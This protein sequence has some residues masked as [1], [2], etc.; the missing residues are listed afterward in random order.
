[1]V[2]VLNEGTRPAPRWAGTW[3]CPNCGR[4]IVLEAGDE[5]GMCATNAERIEHGDCEY[6][7][8][9]SNAGRSRHIL[10]Y[11]PTCMA[12]SDYRVVRKDGDDSMREARY[13]V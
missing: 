10:T 7:Y 12:D 9:T 11:C 13:G 2:K 8:K 5:S 4:V 1:M 6:V 3:R